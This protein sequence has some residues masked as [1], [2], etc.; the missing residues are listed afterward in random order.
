MQGIV[1]MVAGLHHLAYTLVRC[2]TGLILFSHGY[3]KVFEWQLGGMESKFKEMGVLL[4]HISGPFIGLLELIGG[5]LLFVGLFTRY[6]GLLFAAEFVVATY[7]VWV[8][9]NE[10][11]SGSQLELMLLAVAFLLACQGAGRYSADTLLRRSDA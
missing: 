3:V 8:K 10:R 5:A 6:L 2:L 4:P 7:F 11:F 1:A 9:F